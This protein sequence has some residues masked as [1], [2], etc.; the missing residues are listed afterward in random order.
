[1]TRAGPLVTVHLELV[2]INHHEN[3][4]LL[5]SLS[6]LHLC[7]PRSPHTFHNPSPPTALPNTPPTKR[8]QALR[9]TPSTNHPTFPSPLIR[10]SRNTRRQSIPPSHSKPPTLPYSPI[11]GSRNT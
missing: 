11:R 9:P 8:T 6:P 3:F 1:M 2:S 10:G 4:P 7:R 5:H